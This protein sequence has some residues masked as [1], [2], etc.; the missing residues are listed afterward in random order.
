M[1]R[2][3]LTNSDN[4][5]DEKIIKINNL[6]C[7]CGY[8]PSKHELIRIRALTN[9]DIDSMLTKEEK[10]EIDNIIEEIEKSGYVGTLFE[11]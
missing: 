9:E 2:I 11:K 4:I 3:L 5:P 7:R 8:N 10:I 6:G 1:S